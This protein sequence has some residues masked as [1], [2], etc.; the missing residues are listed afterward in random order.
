MVLGTRGAWQLKGLG[1]GR[2]EF[3]LEEV[4]IVKIL[5]RPG[6]LGVPGSNDVL[7]TLKTFGGGLVSKDDMSY[8]KLAVLVQ[9]DL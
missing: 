4:R 9:E 2:P 1:F 6:Q 3:L 7:R 8:L 5:G